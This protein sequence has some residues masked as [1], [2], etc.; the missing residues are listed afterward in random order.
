MM[1]PTMDVFHLCTL[2]WSQ[3]LFVTPKLWN[4]C[5]SLVLFLSERIL[6]QK[7]KIKKK[8]KKKKKKIKDTCC[9]SATINSPYVLHEVPSLNTLTGEEENKYKCAPN[10]H[11]PFQSK[12]QSSLNLVLRQAFLRLLFL[13]F[14]W[15]GYFH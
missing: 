3:V 2:W 14:F 12:Y 15:N 13:F 4:A 7:I 8:K 6:E 5:S 9:W 11:H 1:I 10:V